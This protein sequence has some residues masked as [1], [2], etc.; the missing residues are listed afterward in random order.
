MSH[1]ATFNISH[2]KY[3]ECKNH[4][5]NYILG[6]LKDNH[7]FIIKNKQLLIV[8]GLHKMFDNTNI[9]GKE[10]SVYNASL[11]SMANDITVTIQFD[12]DDFNI[13][14]NPLII[15]K[16][17]KKE[18][19]N[20]IIKN[21]IAIINLKIIDCK[22]NSNISY[23]DKYELLKNDSKSFIRINNKWD[24]KYLAFV[25]IAIC[26]LYGILFTILLTII[27]N[28][29]NSTKII[30]LPGFMYSVYKYIEYNVFIKK[31]NIIQTLIY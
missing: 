3:S 27:M 26:I 2:D 25:I 17:N 13:I 12:L 7:N 14:I 24:L 19:I 15:L 30:I 31:N 16:N 18:T 4:L 21:T 6:I 22:I 9:N 28:Y 29:N 23:I 20:F 1:T 8:E 5:G 10:Y 11:V